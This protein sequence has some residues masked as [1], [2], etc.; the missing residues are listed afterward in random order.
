VTPSADAVELVKRFE[1]CHRRQGNVFVP[2]TCPAG[3]LTIGWGHTNAQHRQFDKHARWTQ[4][5]C[6]AALLEDLAVVGEQVSG[7]L[8][9][10]GAAAIGQHR[11]DALVSFV[12][13]VGIGAFKRSTLLR[14]VN[15]RDYARAALEFHR[16]NR[17]GGKVLP[18]L[19]RRRAAEALLFAGLAGDRD[20]PM[21]QAVDPPGSKVD[22]S[23]RRH[24]A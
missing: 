20:D 11:F 24:G 7:Q 9:G 17:S 23:R 18:G 16:W 15:E 21:P 12:F 8:H 5:D 3:V 22:R 6:D 10:R 1:G 2:Y 14:R 13:N 19:V 4:V